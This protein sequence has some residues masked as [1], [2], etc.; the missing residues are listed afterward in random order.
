MAR[1]DRLGSARDVLQI[2]AA[3]GRDF[4]M[5]FTRETCNITV[6]SG[7]SH[8]EGGMT[9]LAYGAKDV[10]KFERA[11]FGAPSR[12]AIEKS[13]KALNGH[14][15]KRF[16]AEKAAQADAA[17]FTKR[18]QQRLL[19]DLI[20]ND[21]LL[22]SDLEKRRAILKRSPKLVMPRPKI[23]PQMKPV[24]R[25]VAGSL[26]WIKS[27][28]LDAQFTNP[29]TE[30]GVFADSNAG[31]YGLQLQSIEGGSY[32]AAAGLGT[33]FFAPAQDSMQT[34]G[35]SFLFNSAWSDSAYGFTADNQ[36]TTNIWVWGGLENAWVFQGN[37]T[38]AWSDHATWFDSHSGGGSSFYFQDATFPAL[39]NGTYAV[40]FWSEGFVN[41]SG[42]FFGGSISTLGFNALVLSVSFS[43]P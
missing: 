32:R 22:R 17:R 8:Q 20:K 5:N 2:G 35:V 29:P 16:A 14:I 19:A 6:P 40:W 3:I 41:A 24:P 36:L 30:I 15:S 10:R 23:N 33:A 11:L 28:P 12:A 4:R 43:T 39:A 18:V 21:P 27:P 1:V 7:Y 42:S 13:R 34:F 37:G 25:V 31:V 9:I 26:E 38:P